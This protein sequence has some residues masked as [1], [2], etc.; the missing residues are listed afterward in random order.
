VVAEVGGALHARG[1]RRVEYP[2]I[3]I[4]TDFPPAEVAVRRFDLKRAPGR[5]GYVAGAG[6]EV[7]A[8]LRQAGY[9]V[10]L[11]DDAAL[12]HEPLGRYG[13]IVVGVRAFNTRPRLLPLLPRL[14]GYVA[15]GGT[16]VEQ[17]NT[18][19][20]LAPLKERLGPFPFELS[21]QRVTDERAPVRFESPAHPLL[22]RP[23]RITAADFDGWVQE[24]GLYFAGTWSDRYQTVLSMHDPGEPPRRGS[25]LYARHG[26]GT[27]VYTGLAFFR[28]LPAGVPGAYKL[29]LNLVA[30]RAN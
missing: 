11:L 16:L 5:I 12:A 24:R 26:K 20:R 1:L 21:Q 2:H 14:L 28:Q 9:D 29:F 17:Y 25:L 13:A 8:A 4:V 18:N 27:F 22:T 6:D 23:N 10:T 19:N 7:P 3:P 15:A 30:A